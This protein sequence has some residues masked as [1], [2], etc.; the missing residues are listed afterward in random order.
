M[1]ERTIETGESGLGKT[2]ILFPDRA[3]THDVLIYRAA[4]ARPARS[5]EEYAS[6]GALLRDMGTRIVRW[7]SKD[8]TGKSWVEFRVNADPIAE[9]TQ[10][11]FLVGFPRQARRRGQSPDYDATGILAKT[12]DLGFLLKYCEEY[13]TFEPVEDVASCRQILQPFTPLSRV[14]L[15]MPKLVIAVDGGALDSIAPWDDTL[16]PGSLHVTIHAMLE[17]DRL[18]SARIRVWAPDFDGALRFAGPLPPT[19]F[20]PATGDPAKD[21]LRKVAKRLSDLR[22]GSGHR[23]EMELA[24][25][26][27]PVPSILVDALA[28]ARG[29]QV[30]K[31]DMPPAHRELATLLTTAEVESLFVLPTPGPKGLPGIPRRSQATFAVPVEL[32]KAMETDRAVTL[33]TALVGR[34]RMR[35]EI[36]LGE[37]DLRGHAYVCGATGTGKSTLLLNVAVSLARRGWGICLLDPHGQLADMVLKRIP[38]ERQKDVLL[39]DPSDS[40]HRWTL[41]LL[42]QAKTEE[43]QDMVVDQ[44]ISLLARFVASEYMGPMFQQAIRNALLLL[45]GGGGTLNDL[46]PVLTSKDAREPFLG[47]LPESNRN[48]T[49]RNYWEKLYPTESDRSNW[50]NYKDNIPYY[51]CKFERLLGPKTVRDCLSGSRPLDLGRVIAQNGILIARLDKGGL[52]EVN[53]YMLGTLLMSCIMNAMFKRDPKVAAQNTPTALILDE[54]QNY[55][56]S[57]SAFHMDGERAVT[58]R[59]VG[60]LLSESRK[61]GMALVMANQYLSQ[62]DRGTREAVLGN[63]ATQIAFRVS[64]KDAEILAETWADRVH[65]H[66]LTALPNYH[67]LCRTMGGGEASPAF[68]IMTIPPTEIPEVP[69]VEMPRHEGAPKHRTAGGREY[70]ARPESGAEAPAFSRSEMGPGSLEMEAARATTL[71]YRGASEMIDGFLKGPGVGKKIRSY[72]Y[73]GWTGAVHESLKGGVG[74]ACEMGCFMHCFLHLPDEE[75]LR[76]A[77]EPG[78]WPLRIERYVALTLELAVEHEPPLNKDNN[79]RARARLL[80]LECKKVLGMPPAGMLEYLGGKGEGLAYDEPSSKVGSDKAPAR[81]QGEVSS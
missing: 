3:G 60:P 28:G 52:G 12:R 31:A 81:L 43:E 55:V 36:G 67:A 77:S 73:E 46:I 48:E 47:R 32:G 56:S 34:S 41:P 53:A 24:Y 61:F 22:L 14:S 37:A 15:G 68:E 17:L 65:P 49:V 39:F 74:H 30:V 70:A 66:D 25:A 50:N 51:T 44:V 2:G 13:F 69:L 45:M 76:F 75:K 18:S 9:T 63:C 10:V 57:A 40:A 23:V 16:R 1:R 71:C 6:A 78:R 42:G 62:L 19:Y 26:G 58:D 5:T 72:L 54:F 59:S 21:F 38:A 27:S 11:A 35:R 80:Q 79:R 20:G 64:R 7:L 4:G 33:G 29:L 8:L